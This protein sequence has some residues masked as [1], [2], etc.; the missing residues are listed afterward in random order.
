MD[1]ATAD[2][3]AMTPL[4]SGGLIPGDGLIPV[5]QLGSDGAVEEWLVYP[6]HTRGWDAGSLE[7]GSEYHSRAIGGMDSLSMLPSVKMSVV[8]G[9]EDPVASIEMVAH[10]KDDG[11]MTVVKGDSLIAFKPGLVSGWACSNIK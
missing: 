7:L 3:M 4:S 6:G 10:A 9:E 2:P 1:A 11:M 5:D 8:R